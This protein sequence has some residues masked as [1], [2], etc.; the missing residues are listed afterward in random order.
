MAKNVRS[1]QPSFMRNFQERAL[2]I[3]AVCL[4]IIPIVFV[5]LWVNGLVD[6]YNHRDT[7]TVSTLSFIEKSSTPQLFSEPLVSVTFDDGWTSA[8]NNGMPLL[9]KYHIR[10]TQFLLPGEFDDPNY[11][12][13][14]QAHS[15]E[16][17][18]HEIGSHTVDHKNLTQL[19][20]TDVNNE[21]AVSKSMLQKENLV[22]AHVNFASPNSAV[23]DQVIQNVKKVYSSHR[24]TLADIGNGMSAADINLGPVLPR[25]NI[26][27]FSIR[28]NTTIGQIKQALDYAKKNNGWLVLVYHQIDDSN[29]L[30][31]ANKRAFESHLQLVAQSKIKI[32]TI[33][34]VIATNPREQ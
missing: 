10:T 23:N 18:G 11:V 5:G 20:E 6:E 21:L 27:G 25:Y 14:N 32:V 2:N 19:D 3:L 4:A 13:I 12:S 30:F 22:P 24:N 17:A 7:R 31:S 29:E 8:Y 16:K 33:G 34:D 15:M 26:I 1:Q 28:N 9:S